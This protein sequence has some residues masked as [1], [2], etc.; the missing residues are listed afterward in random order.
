[1]WFRVSEHSRSTLRASASGVEIFARITPAILEILLG[2][3]VS[4]IILS[5]LSH[6]AVI[7]IIAIHLADSEHGRKLICGV[8]RHCPPVGLLI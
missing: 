7:Q 3:E 5:E 8:S 6:W 4:V 2:L 1:M